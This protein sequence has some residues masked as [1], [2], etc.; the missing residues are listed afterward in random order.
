MEKKKKRALRARVHESHEK[1]V[2]KLIH[3][4]MD[5]AEAQDLVDARIP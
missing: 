5:P 3:E 4:G 1:E 2:A